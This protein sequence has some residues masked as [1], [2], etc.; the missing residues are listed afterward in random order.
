[1]VASYRLTAS[2]AQPST[3]AVE[4][5]CPGVYVQGSVS[6]RCGRLLARAVPVGETQQKCPRCGTYTTF[7]FEAGDM[8]DVTASDRM[9]ASL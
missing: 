8:T 3:E 2:T 1:M 6:R 4:L 7:T 9:G 5:R